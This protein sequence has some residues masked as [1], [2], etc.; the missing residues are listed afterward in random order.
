M[1]RRPKKDFSESMMKPL[2]K[3]PWFWLIIVALFAL[4]LPIYEDEEKQ[5]PEDIND[6]FYYSARDA[7]QDFM[8]GWLDRQVPE[9]SVSVEWTTYHYEQIQSG[10]ETTSDRE[11][12][13]SSEE[14]VIELLH[15]MLTELENYEEAWSNDQAYER[16]PFFSTASEVANKLNIETEDANIAE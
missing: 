2:W 10:T 1:E 11:P 16:E 12:L 5:I 4:T 3:A 8:D 6:S 9:D 7:Y 14:E 15:T 13:S